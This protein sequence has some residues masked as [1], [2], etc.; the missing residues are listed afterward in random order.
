MPCIRDGRD[1]VAYHQQ[2]TPA[3]CGP[4]SAMMIL[5]ALG[6]PLIQ[7]EVLA[8]RLVAHDGRPVSTTDWSTAPASLA[9]GL[10]VWAPPPYQ[11]AFAVHTA[12]TEADATRAIVE[13]I[14]D[15][16]APPPAALV[17]GKGHWV[18]V[19]DVNVEDD[20]VKGLFLNIPTV[21]PVVPPGQHAD[22]DGC[23]RELRFGSVSANQYVSYEAWK[24]DYF[25]GFPDGGGRAFVIVATAPASGPGA[26]A[27]ASSATPA[28][29]TSASAQPANGGL[30][31]P[32]RAGQLVLDGIAE[33]GL[34]AGGPLKDVLRAV[35]PGTPQLVDRIDM[36]LWHYY[37]VPLL[38]GGAEVAVARLDAVYGTFMGVSSTLP[39]ELAASPQAAAAA[40]AVT[41]EPLPEGSSVA[42][43]LVWQ[44]CRESLSPFDAFRQI[45][46]PDAVLFQSTRSGRLHDAL[47]PLGAG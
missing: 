40:S 43:R 5:R 35:Q 21:T 44:P 6:V 29:T 4:A 11:G 7:Q 13:T 36:T 41:L 25:T 19:T 15:T 22:A 34:D 37:L 42:S 2:N 38:R 8:E 45:V 3:F 47:S 46:A 9:D 10:N 30:I 20:V 33:H 24:T 23:G 14:R 17:Y 32:E 16:A 31:A 39:E 1:A 28:S 12:R 18:V 26:S 27:A